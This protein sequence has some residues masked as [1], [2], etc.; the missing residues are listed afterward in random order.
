M[1]D[2]YVNRALRLNRKARQLTARY[3]L[4]CH[5]TEEEALQNTVITLCANCRKELE[6]QSP[7]ENHHFPSRKWS[8]FTIPL[9]ANDHAI[10]TGQSYDHPKEFRR[11][12]LLSGL[13]ARLDFLELLYQ[14]TLNAIKEAESSQPH[15]PTLKG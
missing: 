5:T 7:Y 6:G 1:S 12:K 4:R 10:L 2:C 15:A 8:D 9:L 11:D 14:Q 3:C 13:Y